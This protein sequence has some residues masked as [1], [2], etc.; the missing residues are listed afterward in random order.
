MQSGGLTVTILPSA[1]L[2][3]HEVRIRAPVSHTGRGSRVTHS[4]NVQDLGCTPVL[5]SLIWSSSSKC[6]LARFT[7]RGTI[8]SIPQPLVVDGGRHP[9]AEAGDDLV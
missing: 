1:F 9:G 7:P 2:G 8:S 4:V 6:N 3:E 5:P